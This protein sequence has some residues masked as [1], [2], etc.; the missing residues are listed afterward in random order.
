M[1]KYLQIQFCHYN[2]MPFGRQSSGK[3]RTGPG[4][5]WPQ[6]NAQRRFPVS[7]WLFRLSSFRTKDFLHR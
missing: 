1:S 5:P 6:N 3:R 2:E 7:F 4:R